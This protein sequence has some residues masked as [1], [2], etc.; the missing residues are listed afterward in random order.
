M[1]FSSLFGDLTAGATDIMSMGGGDQD[2]IDSAA[3]TLGLFGGIF[4]AALDIADSLDLLPYTVSDEVN[5]SAWKAS[6]TID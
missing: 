3:G 4:G 5:V 6:N 2:D 1:S